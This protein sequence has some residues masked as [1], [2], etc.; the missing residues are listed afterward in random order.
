MHKSIELE[1]QVRLLALNALLDAVR[2]PVNALAAVP[3]GL[4]RIEESMRQSG[5]EEAI[6]EQCMLAAILE[7]RAA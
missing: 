5:L 1:H 6:A 7:P 3:E 4:I 2:N